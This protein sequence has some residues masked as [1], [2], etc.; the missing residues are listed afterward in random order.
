MNLVHQAFLKDLHD[1]AESRF[2]SYDVYSS[3][4]NGDQDIDIPPKVLAALESEL[5]TVVNY[6]KLV[7][8]SVV[9]YIM[10]G[11]VNLRV[12]EEDAEEALLGVYEANGLLTEEMSK[13]ITVMGKKG[14]VYLKLFI[15]DANTVQVR[16]LRPDIVFPRYKTDDYTELHYVAV[17][18]FEDADD[19]VEGDG[20]KWHAQVFR[21]DVIE[22][23]ELEGERDTQSTSWE[24][25]DTQPNKL[26]F[27]PIVHIKNTT[28]DLE[29]GVSDLQ[30]MT[31]LQDALNK[32][33]TDMLL[34]MDYQAFQRMIV[35][36]S[37]S[38]QGE[39]LPMAP[40][41]IMEV[42]NPEGH[43]DVIEAAD[44]S[45]FI[46]GMKVIVD[47]ITAVTQI[48]KISTMQTGSTMPESGIALKIHY[49]SMESK[50][51]KKIII[52]KRRFAELDQ[53]IFKALAFTG[54][55]DFSGKR[56]ELLFKNGLPIDTEA[57]DKTDE[58]E[59]VHGISSRRKIMIRRGEKDVETEMSEIEGDDF[60]QTSNTVQV[61]EDSA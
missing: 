34:A 44:I 2:H 48:S 23:Y 38:P 29:F 12:E 43:A 10:G 39:Q 14:D 61:T 22:F 52:L 42:S 58:F 17:K 40:G 7:V 46:E 55:P 21:P 32:T 47:H 54:Q 36:G 16:V 24:L 56:T 20:G 9:D 19:F 50:A 30:V 4:Y 27:I 15:D 3:Y 35:F 49:I 13:T 26:G 18:W 6:S 33:M 28:D 31:D 5:G 53:M 45:G 25:V 1:Q 8:D 51:G 60:T 41:E 57:Q 59:L 11:G 37:Q